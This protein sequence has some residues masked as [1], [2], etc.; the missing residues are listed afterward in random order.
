M[1]PLF[2]LQYRKKSSKSNCPEN[3]HFFGGLGEV[4]LRGVKKKK[5]SGLNSPKRDLSIPSIKTLFLVCLTNRDS[6]VPSH[7]CESRPTEE[8]E[9]VEQSELRKNKKY[10]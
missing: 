4:H 8:N 5:K 9:I 1:L 7:K 3:V 2:G 6:T 10:Q